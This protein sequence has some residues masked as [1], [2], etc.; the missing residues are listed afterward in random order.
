MAESLRLIQMQTPQEVSAAHLC[1]PGRAGK[2]CSLGLATVFHEHDPYHGFSPQKIDLQGWS[3]GPNIYETLAKMAK[4]RMIIEVGVWKGTSASYLAK[5]LKEQNEGVLF[6]VDTWLGALEFW[7][8]RITKGEYDP[9]RDLVF[10]NGYPGVYYQFLSNV[11]Q[12]K[13]SQFVVPFPS[14]SRMASEFFAEL[15]ATADLIHI[16]AAHEYDD[17]KEDVNRWWPLVREG[18]ILMGD[19]YTD[20]WSGVIKAVNEFAEEKHLKLHVDGVKWWLS[21]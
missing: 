11:V 15:N 9:E 20:H 5:T 2:N 12:Q 4:A 10:K 6:A 3:P 13:L 21:K 7:N 17:V 1:G 8:R 19:D 16:D 14:T 18:G